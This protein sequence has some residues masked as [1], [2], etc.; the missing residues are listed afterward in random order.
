M[1][2]PTHATTETQT[3]HTSRARHALAA[4]GQGQRCWEPHA[5]AEN[6]R[7]QMQEVKSQGQRPWVKC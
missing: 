4:A 7:W 3:Q 6:T 2:H 5:H 1:A